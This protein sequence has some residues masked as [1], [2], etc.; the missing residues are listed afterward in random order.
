[1]IHVSQKTRPPFTTGSRENVSLRKLQLTNAQKRHLRRSPLFCQLFIWI[2]NR[3]S[4]CKNARRRWR[5]QG[6]LRHPVFV[7]SSWL[8]PLFKWNFPTKTWHAFVLT[9]FVLPPICLKTSCSEKR[10][11][12]KPYN[13]IL[14]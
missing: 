2:S 9:M 7:D 11:I 12:M 8:I 14:H 5:L 10:F 13:T 6:P 4:L 1:M 3:I